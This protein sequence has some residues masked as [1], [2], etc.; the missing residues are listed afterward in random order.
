MR[1]L[2]PTLLAV[3]A[4]ATACA[5]QNYH[6]PKNDL[7]A[8]SQTPPEQ[9]GERVRVI[10]G[11]G[12]EDDPPE[13]PPHAHAGVVVVVDAPVWVDGRPHHHGYAGPSNH[14]GGGGGGGGLS[15]LAAA[16][17]ENAKAWLVVA[18]I[19][20]G[21][22]IATEGARYD[23]W[24]KLHPMHPVH[25]YGP[26][27]EYTWMP[28]AQITPDVANWASKAV[29]RENE[30]PWQP[31][32]RAPLDRQ[33]FTYSVLMGGSQISAIGLDPLSG[34]MGHIDLGYFPAPTVGL[35]LDIGMG[36]ADDGF[37]NT[38]FHGRHGLEL[39]VLPV[40]A[41]V[42][43]GGAYGELGASTRSDDGIQVDDSDYFL[44]GGGLLQLELTTRLAL[45][46][47]AGLNHTFGDNLAEL[48]GGVSIY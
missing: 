32:G 2:R 47:R 28:L 7:M 27:G 16:K 46:L 15:N 41:G 20:A 34:F 14:T 4:V 25:L 9:R 23:G 48:T 45:T 8:L 42:I 21:A 3:A 43:H 1:F 36:W 39:D 18:A 11:L 6:I 26:N 35:Q 29:V 40:S 37:G 19:V 24:V 33:G 38:V 5:S 12:S 30:G 44:A 13:Q 10:Q 31:L 22:L 17:K